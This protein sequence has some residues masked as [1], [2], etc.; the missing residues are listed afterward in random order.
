MSNTTII[1]E[2]SRCGRSRDRLW[3]AC[4]RNIR[5]SVEKYTY[6]CINMSINQF[7]TTILRELT[8]MHFSRV[9][10]RVL[11]SCPCSCCSRS[12]CLTSLRGVSR[13]HAQ[14]RADLSSFSW[15]FNLLFSP[16]LPLFPAQHTAGTLLSMCACAFG[17]KSICQEIIT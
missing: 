16:L 14:T 1:I 11:C 5:R 10:A 4:S 3:R 9:H 12:C 17:S 2:W 13:S 8:T 7:N 15:S 6:V